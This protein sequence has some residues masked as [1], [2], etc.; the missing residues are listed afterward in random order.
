MVLVCR[1]IF[2]DFGENFLVVD[3]SE[4]QLSSCFIQHITKAEEGVVFCYTDTRHNL[5]DGDFV[6]FSEVGG[7]K[8][9]NSYKPQE[10]KVLTPY[11]FSICDTSKLPAYTGGGIATEYKIPPFTI[12]FVSSCKAF[13]TI[14]YCN[15]VI[16]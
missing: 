16:W 1:S 8:A 12:H 6:S 7:M 9:L 2:C 14:N 10:I 13:I 5:E 15:C 4:E 11:S 3:K